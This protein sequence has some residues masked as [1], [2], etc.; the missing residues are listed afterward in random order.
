MPAQLIRLESS[1]DLVDQVYRSLLDAISDGTFAPGTRLTQEEIAAQLAV[2]RQP[3]LQA[4]RLLRQDGFVSDAPGRGVCVAAL[5][6]AAMLQVYEVR[7]ALDGLAVRLAARHHARI[8]PKLIEQGRRAARG[9]KVKAM[10]DADLAF[11]A[12]I[13]T[14]SGNPLIEQSAQRH[15]QHLRR[16]MGAVLLHSPQRE[17]VWDEHEAIA[18]AIADGQGR[19]AAQLIEQHVE[20]ASANLAQRLSQLPGPSSATSAATPSTSHPG[21]PR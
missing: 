4:L 3:V 11:H 18:Q 6:P 5:D 15:W 9:K 12:A 17:S 14:A 8:D 7:G 1:P 20:H 19:R 21:N 13:Y 16:V 2:S 10:I